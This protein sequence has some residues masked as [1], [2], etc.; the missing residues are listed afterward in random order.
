MTAID[1]IKTS[2]TRTSLDWCRLKGDGGYTASGVQASPGG[3]AGVSPI[4]ANLIYMKNRNHKFTRTPVLVPTPT[5]SMKQRCMI[6]TQACVRKYGKSFFY[7][8]M[9]GGGSFPKART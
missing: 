8:S 4:S 3:V 5:N 1:W 2:V 6:R 7:G 9:S